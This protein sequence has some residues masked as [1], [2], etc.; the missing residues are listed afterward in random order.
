MSEADTDQ[1]PAGVDLRRSS[2]RGIAYAVAGRNT[3]RV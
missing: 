3:K 1:L 2:M